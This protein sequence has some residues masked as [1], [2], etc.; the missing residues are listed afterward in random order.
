VVSF[1]KAVS[2]ENLIEEGEL[3]EAAEAHESDNYGRGQEDLNDVERN[4]QQTQDHI[5]S[6]V[7]LAHSSLN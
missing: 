3:E 7:S 5:Q 2:N 1:F 6:H 4:G